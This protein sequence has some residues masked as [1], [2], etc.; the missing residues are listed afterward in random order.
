MVDKSGKLSEPSKTEKFT[1]KKNKAPRFVDGP[2]SVEEDKTDTTIKLSVTAADDDINDLLT[3]KIEYGK[4]N[5]EERKEYIGNKTIADIEQ[6]IKQEIEITELSGNT[7]YY[8]EVVVI[9]ENQISTQVEKLDIKTY[10]RG[11]ECIGYL[12]QE[13]E[14]TTCNHTR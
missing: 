7:N 14:C 1:I 8:F 10:C 4:Y 11:K 13:T 12:N 2:K 6:G 5:E 3:Y 9:D